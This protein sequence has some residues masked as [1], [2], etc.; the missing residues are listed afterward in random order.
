MTATALVRRIAFAALALCCATAF[1]TQPPETRIEPATDTYFGTTVL[2]PCRWLED[3]RAPDVHDW[4]AAQN[5]YTRSVLDALPRRAALRDRIAALASADERVANV[6]WGGELLFYEKRGPQQDRFDL[7]VR[8]GVD[9][10]ERLL[11]DPARF[12]A[13]GQPAA[14]SF[15][16]PSPNGKRIA[17]GISLGGSEDATLRVLDVASGREV[18]EPVPRMDIGD[19]ASWRIDSGA[20]FYTQLNALKPGEDAVEKFRNGH[21]YM[22]DFAGPDRLVFGQGVDASI[23]LDPD[24][25]VRVRSY[26]SSFAIAI[27]EHGNENELTL[28]AAPLAQVGL[29]HT[30]WRRIASVQDGVTAF[31]VRGEWIYLV[32]NAQ[33]PRYRVVRWSLGEAQPLALDRAGVV[34]PESPRVITGLSVAKDA[35]YVQQMDGGYGRLLRLEFNVKLPHPKSGKGSKSRR[36]PAALPKTAGVARAT[37][38]ALP[39]EGTIEARVTDPMRAGAL[40]RLA[41]WTHAPAYYAVQPGNGALVK[42]SLQPPSHVDFSGVEA[43][44]ILV[45]SHDGV[46]VPVSIVY[47]RSVTRNGEAPLLL[48]AYGAYGLSQEPYFWPSLLAWLERGGVFA[49]AHVRG[50]GEFGKAWHEAGRLSNKPNTWLDLIAAA[51]ALVREKWTS[52]AHLAIVGGSAGGIAVGGAMVTRPDLFRAVV[53]QVGVHDLLRNELTSNGPSNITEFGTV[54]T[55]AGFRTLYA[56]SSYHHV[57]DGVVYP[58]ALFTTGYND[59]RVDSWQPGKMAARLQAVNAGL[60]GS[61]HPVLLRVDFAGGHGFGST[62]QQAI[63]ETADEFAF[64]LWQVGNGQ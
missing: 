35:L 17:F 22:R 52:P 27:V 47:A 63:E 28:Y 62:K 5:D 48:D 7:Y 43:T 20:L 38:I 57:K 51:E 13:N 29:P 45:K 61:G 37:E 12:D 39:F 14:I 8:A 49:V 54:T 15:Y 30:P 4:F 32:S 9:G 60:G 3:L 10:P 50:G 55:E 64:L 33:A 16:I 25:T 59:P 21:V 56:M 53:S 11:V 58:A 44:R 42:L 41:G 36:A 23:A 2:D 1:A 26:L 19:P 34:V 40:V 18:G 24:D 6:Q 31:D 46:E